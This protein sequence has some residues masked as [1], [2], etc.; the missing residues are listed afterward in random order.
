ME[1]AIALNGVVVQAN[2]AAFRWGRH[3]LHTPGAAAKLMEAGRPGDNTRAG[4]LGEPLIGG[5]PM[6][7]KTFRLARIRAGELVLYQGKRLARDYLDAVERV[8]IAE[9]NVTDHTELSQTVAIQLYR[10]T[11]YKDEYE[12]ARLLIDP[13][14][15]ASLRSQLPGSRKL[16]F[17][18]HP[19]LLRSLGLTHKIAVGPWAR[20][21]LR[22]LAVGR[23][24]RGTWL[25]P[26][27]HT[28]I[29]RVER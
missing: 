6:A 16:R 13:A 26:F 7:G 23:R 18:L 15:T 28:H 25:D 8:W 17:R 3:F 1:R 29:R 20:P 11:A 9:R 22:L 2:V 24:L 12:V 10:L 27:G 21:V 19:P 4:A 5:R 14:F